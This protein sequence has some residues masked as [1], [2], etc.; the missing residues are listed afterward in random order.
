MNL[1][2]LVR[3]ARWSELETAWTE[4]ALG[5]AALAPALVAVAAAAG[6]KGIP[7]LLPLVR[8]HAEVL[9]GSGRAAQAAELLGQTMLAG[10]SPGEIA[11][12]L[13]AA[14]ESAWRE[15][16]F[17]EVFREIAQL[18]ENVPDMR[19][20]WRAFRKLL[21]LEPGRV[22]Y[23]AAGWGLGEIT[24]VDVGTRL[25][26]VRFASGRADRFPLQTTVDIFEVL[27]PGDL[28]R[29]VVQDPGELDRLLKK[30]PLEVLRWVL[31]RNDGKATQA[32]IKLAMGTLGVDG[33]RFVSW[34]KKAH[35]EAEGSEWFEITGPPGRALVR[36]LQRAEDPSV[37]LRRQLLRS[38]DLDEAFS[39]IKTL[40][41]GGRVG[42]SVRAAALEVLE[43]LA[44]DERFDLSSRLAAWLFLREKRGA[45]P[46]E[47]S[48]KLEAARAAPPPADRSQPAGLWALF[49]EV[50][51]LREQERCVEV[52]REALGEERWLD[53]VARSLQHAS[54]GMVRGLVDALDSA[55]RQDALVQH[56]SALLARP[57]RNPVLLVRLAERIEPTG[58]SERLGPP[59]PRAQTLL[60][61][62][63]HLQRASIANSTLART[64][65]RL[66]SLLTD[67]KPPLLRRLLEGADIEILRPLNSLIESGVDRALDRVFT[68]IA[69]GVSPDVFRAEERA[70]WDSPHTWT[71]RAGLAR[72]HEELRIL[73]DVKIPE[74]AEAI[75]RAAS[76]G[77]LS[78]NSE[79][80]AAIE[81]QRQLTNRAMDLEA[82]LENARLIESAI[83]PEGLVGPGMRVR[84]QE[85]NTGLMRE[86][87]ILG[88]WDADGE[89]VVSDRSPLAAG[90]LGR[91]VGE[92]ADLILPAEILRVR[93]LSIE[94]LAL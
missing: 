30:E 65:T 70:F 19:A 40:F 24:A 21:A 35:K 88:P 36:L 81:D 48:A 78:E 16:P 18:R 8:E 63:V 80:E 91:S 71:T 45:T 39:R 94:P 38:R 62:A 12:P 58:L 86:V 66:T 90:M 53:E 50:P 74:N 54:P 61:L 3:E 9:A 49:Q 56:Y 43:E 83:L 32:G 17:W 6:R 52:L 20:A 79:W 26:S 7:R 93:V 27:E 72:R 41:V 47:L 51:G 25:V 77:D 34:W 46:A 31:A 10:G 92:E 2:Q 60:Q 33:P 55:G 87:D 5:E 44:A 89:R 14:A 15:Q 68:Q 23:H 64:R 67:G 11:R 59:L 75:G 57:T 84:F 29:L 42:E 22:V 1:A 69:V 82:E 37:G 73:R 28:R 85:V 13:L 76:Y 4:L